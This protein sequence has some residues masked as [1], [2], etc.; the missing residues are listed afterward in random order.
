M[1]IDLRNLSREIVRLIIKA[2]SE[3][4][5]LNLALNDKKGNS[6]PVSNGVD[7]LG[8]HHLLSGGL[9]L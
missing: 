2:N 4:E 3:K 7:F 6:L 1:G 9:F 8:N 5:R